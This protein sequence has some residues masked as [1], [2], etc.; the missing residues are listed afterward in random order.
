MLA[1][2]STIYSFPLHVHQANAACQHEHQKKTK[3]T[4][5]NARVDNSTIKNQHDCQHVD[6]ALETADDRVTNTALKPKAARVARNPV[7]IALG[8]V[9]KE[10]RSSRG[11]SSAAVAKELEVSASLYR[12]YESG[13]SALGPSY[14]HAFAMMF[15]DDIE[16]SRMSVVVS[17]IHALEAP[18]KKGSIE[19]A[20]GNCQAINE[21]SNCPQLTYLLSEFQTLLESG[22]DDS[23]LLNNRERLVDWMS[24][25]VTPSLLRY[26]GGDR[27]FDAGG[28]SMVRTPNG[29]MFD[30]SEL[31]PVFDD[32]L[33]RMVG[34]LS[35]FQLETRPETLERWEF[36]S[37]GRFAEVVG[38]VRSASIMASTTDTFAWQYIHSAPFK[39]LR[40]MV[41]QDPDF[42]T[43]VNGKL[44][45]E[46]DWAEEFVNA[47]LLGDARAAQKVNFEFVGN[48]LEAELAE[49]EDSL[50]AF[51]QRVNNIWLYR[52]QGYTPNSADK[53]VAFVDSLR[54]DQLTRGAREKA[55][56]LPENQ[57]EDLRR[58][59]NRW[60]ARSQPAARSV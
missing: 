47:A 28:S 1:L 40:V 11:L 14:V 25:S 19:I 55:V 10:L 2:T 50:D 39:S 24:S 46:Q 36:I 52:L 53:Y 41:L 12:L 56:S 32:L 3:I 37:R 4:I 15:E 16:F 6:V 17:L 23:D 20:C 48:Q 60:W 9:L 43:E 45:T 33:E 18:L 31:N 42:R 27:G 34:L 49:W 8:G 44:L 21:T 38:V 26:I 58:R 51:S 57:V 35:C 30:V 5:K 29:R 59:L 13:S 54:P 7:S 22:L